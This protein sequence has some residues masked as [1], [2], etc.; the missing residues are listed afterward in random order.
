MLSHLIPPPIYGV[1]LILQKK[2]KDRDKQFPKIVL[3]VSN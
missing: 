1:G 3:Q 2:K